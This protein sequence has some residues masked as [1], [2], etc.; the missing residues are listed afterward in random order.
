MNRR[1]L[2]FVRQF[3]LAFIL[4]VLA[5]ADNAINLGSRRELFVDWFLIDRLK[6]AELRMHEPIREGVAVKFDNPWEG[7]F[8]GYATVIKDENVYRMYY[9]GLP[10]AG[11]DGSPEAVVAYAES[12]DG[13][14]W[15]KPDLG[16]FVVRGTLHNNVVLT[17]AP[18]DPTISA[19]CGMRTRMRRLRQNTR[20][21]GEQKGCMHLQL[22]RRD[23]L[24]LFAS[25][26]RFRR[27]SAV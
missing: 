25:A 1:P 24:E 26:G 17:N 7:G 15:T 16:L 6:G 2:F 11:R 9:R 21:S 14:A 4:P 13:V 8:S 27:K 3:V 23:S 19:R 20:P 5:C 10:V 12:K 22:S 18:Y